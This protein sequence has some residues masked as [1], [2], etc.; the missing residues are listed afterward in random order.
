MSSLTQLSEICQRLA[1]FGWTALLK[2]HGLN[3]EAPNLEA[4]I[5]KDISATIDRNIS[6]FE[7][8]ISSGRRAV[9]PYIPC[10]SLLFHAFSSPN[11]HPGPGNSMVENQDAYPTLAE[12]DVLENFIFSTHHGASGVAVRDKA[13]FEA[14]FQPANLSIAVFAYQYRTGIRSVN[15]RYADF[16]YS[17]TGVSRVGTA[18][19]VY[20][21]AR[22]SFW[23][24]PENGDDTIP[25]LPARYGLFI[26]E[27]RLATR[28]EDVLRNPN[29]NRDYI[30]PIHKIFSGDDCVRDLTIPAFEFAENHLSE[31]LRRA[32]QAIDIQGS[33][34]NINQAPFITNS[35]SGGNLVRLEP[36][37]SSAILVSEHEESLVQVAEQ[38]GR[39]V[40]F[41]VP[42]AGNR[43]RFSTSFQIPTLDNG[44]VRLGPEYLN[45]RFQ[46]KDNGEVENVSDQFSAAQHDAFLRKV[47]NGGYN[48]VLFTDK[49]CDGCIVPQFDGPNPLTGQILPA[50]SLVTAPDFFPLCDQLE[51]VNWLTENNLTS[52]E[53]FALGAPEPLFGERLHINPFIQLPDSAAAAFPSNRQ[54]QTTVAIVSMSVFSHSNPIVVKD[55]N[56]V[57]FLTDAASGVFAPGWDVSLVF[58][59]GLNKTFLSSS[60][61]G[62]P[63]PE[64]AK[65]C[66][67]L[68]SFWP[69]VAPDASQTFID[70][71][72][73]GAIATAFPMMNSELGYHQEHPLVI[74]GAREVSTGWDGEQGPFFEG[75]FRFVNYTNIERSDYT[76]N[77]LKGTISVKQ[78]CMVGASEWIDRMTVL[79]NCIFILP[80]TGSVP[81]SREMRLVS[82]EKI[83]DWDQAP[84]KVDVRLTGTGFI[85]QFAALEGN[86]LLTDEVLRRKRAVKESY[87]CQI[88]ETFI[89]FREN[90]QLNFQAVRRS[91]IPIRP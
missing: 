51:I 23:T 81:D 62:S 32:F 9:E 69:A 88:S 46:L 20:V 6:G 24:L 4:E 84:E 76:A 78:L 75:P 86:E 12:L 70:D 89:F 42:A 91:A 5:Y 36:I 61:L 33:G 47:K 79:R 11:V 90:S 85:F 77:A 60:G 28:R 49:T 56:Q 71:K 19:P 58:D 1:P 65:L 74:S 7:D 41:N 17:R 87:T 14:N 43:N 57:S 34:F 3:I 27:K 72:I 40:S 26:A 55:H 18:G 48:A 52:R 39:K 31:K 30:F 66:A 83:P 63:F 35:K 82:A 15:E 16:V 64:D 8:F 13:F 73:R 68:N 25:V 22:R 59:R 44:E 2:R 38:N 54:N 37:G 29:D 80:G 67:A 50:Y 53:H 45:I 10:K 21:P